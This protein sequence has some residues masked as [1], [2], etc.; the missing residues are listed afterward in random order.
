M[1]RAHDAGELLD[2]EMN[3]IARVLA[4]IAAQRRRRLE[5]SELFGVAA[6]AAGDRGAGDFGRARDLEAW[7]LPAAQRQDTGHSKRVDGSGGTFGA[8][9]AIAKPCVALGPEAS[10]PLVSATF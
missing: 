6:Q 4:L 9:A 3:E 10:E 1:A 8:G 2:I 5:S 7:Q